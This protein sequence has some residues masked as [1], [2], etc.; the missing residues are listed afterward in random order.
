VIEDLMSPLFHDT[1]Q[2]AKWIEADHGRL[3]ARLGLVRGL[4]GTGRPA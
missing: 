4:N 1:E 2:H 3:K